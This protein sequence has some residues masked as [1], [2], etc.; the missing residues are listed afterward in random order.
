[1][2]GNASSVAIVAAI[3]CF[4]WRRKARKDR[5]VNDFEQEGMYIRSLVGTNL[6]NYI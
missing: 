1:V 5:L 6:E 4:R 2:L 3:V